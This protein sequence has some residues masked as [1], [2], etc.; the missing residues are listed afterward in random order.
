VD[1]YDNFPNGL[2]IRVLPAVYL[3]EKSRRKTARGFSKFPQGLLCSPNLIYQPLGL[4]PG[5][6]LHPRHGFGVH[7]LW[8]PGIRP[9]TGSDLPLKPKCCYF[10]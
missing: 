7:N 8:E 4:K 3:E 6:I 2:L 10:G 1:D 9:D 5:K